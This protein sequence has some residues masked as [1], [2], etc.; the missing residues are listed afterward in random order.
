MLLFFLL[1]R[2]KALKVLF[3]AMFLHFIGQ[4][5]KINQNF[6]SCCWC[7]KIFFRNIFLINPLPPQKKYLLRWDEIRK[8]L[9]IFK[10]NQTNWKSNPCCKKMI[11]CILYFYN[12]WRDRDREKRQTRIREEIDFLKE[13]IKDTYIHIHKCYSFQK[14]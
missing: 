5:R 10:W 12:E 13:A 14:L 7:E 3:L 11:S 9:R 4:G 1:T 8:S 6:K 2:G